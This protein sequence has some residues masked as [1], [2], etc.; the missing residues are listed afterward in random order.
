MALD[1]YDYLIFISIA[2]YF[3]CLLDFY[4][5]CPYVSILLDFYV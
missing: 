4:F 2:P 1:F 5:Y 3:L